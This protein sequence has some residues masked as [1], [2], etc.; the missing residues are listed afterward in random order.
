MKARVVAVVLGGAFLI[1]PASVLAASGQ[2][3]LQP[4]FNASLRQ[5]TQTVNWQ[6]RLASS[7][8]FPR[9]TGSAQYQAQPGQRELQVELEHLRAFAGRTLVVQVDGVTV[10]SMKVSGKGIAQMTLNSELGRRVPVL[11]H[12]STLTVKAAAVV[13][14]SGTF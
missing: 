13:I 10:G 12:H 9:V 5:A 14:A 4:A 11:Q 7:T 2:T 6:I 1:T 3:R 8:R